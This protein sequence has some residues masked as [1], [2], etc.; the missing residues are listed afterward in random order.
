MAAYATSSAPHI[1]SS[2]SSTQR[3]W[4]T[5]ASLFPILVSSLIFFPLDTLRI[6]LGSILAALFSEIAATIVQ[7]KKIGIQN[8]NTIFIAIL[9]AF[10]LP[11]D[12]TLGMA[13]LGA[14]FAIIFGREIFGGLGAYPFHPAILGWVFLQVTFPLAMNQPDGVRASRDLIH[15][16]WGYHGALLGEANL[17][18]ILLSGVLLIAQRLIYWEIPLIFAGVIWCARLLDLTIPI[19]SILYGGVGL[20]AFFIVTDSSTTP[21]S[22][23][24]KRF[25]AL[26]CAVLVILL[27]KISVYNPSIGFAVL[28]CNALSA[29]FDWNFK[30]KGIAKVKL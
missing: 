26:A 24:G 10:L 8:G 6:L 12:A 17:I 29:W 28:F 27:K 7:G 1:R 18:A 25:F 23:N 16:I 20:V 5:T 13:A 22:R 19:E 9:F 3:M 11:H 30:P 15:F 2:E 14:A 21:L 4:R